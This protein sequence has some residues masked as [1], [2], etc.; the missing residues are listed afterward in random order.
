MDIKKDECISDKRN[1]AK[2]LLETLA[3]IKQ[4]EIFHKHNEYVTFHEKK[5]DVKTERWQ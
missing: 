1:Q 5:I 3:T 2:L 4:T